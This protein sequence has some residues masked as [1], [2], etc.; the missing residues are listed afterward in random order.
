MEHWC[1]EFPVHRRRDPTT[2]RRR[3][4]RKGILLQRSNLMEPSCFT[5]LL[6]IESIK[7]HFHRRSTSLTSPLRWPVLRGGGG[8]GKASCIGGATHW[9]SYQY[10]AASIIYL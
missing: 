4:P 10:S 8:L 7:L 1:N 6:R 9:S 3:R 5:P 2:E